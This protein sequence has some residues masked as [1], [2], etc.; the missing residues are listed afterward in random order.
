[1]NTG[2]QCQRACHSIE[3]MGVLTD[4]AVGAPIRSYLPK[5]CTFSASVSM[6][7]GIEHTSNLAGRYR[8]R[9]ICDIGDA[10]IVD[11]FRMVH[12]SEDKVQLASL[13]RIFDPTINSDRKTSAQL[14]HD[15][16]K[17]PENRKLFVGFAKCNNEATDYMVTVQNIDISV[18]KYVK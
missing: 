12:Y 13:N 14:V 17:H 2:K 18:Y 6:S 16:L 11:V 1:M 3:Y 8:S 7:G 10:I 5:H 4:D 15:W 9:F